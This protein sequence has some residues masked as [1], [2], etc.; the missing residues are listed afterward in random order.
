MDHVKPTFYRTI[1]F[2]FESDL[3]LQKEF[4]VVVD[5]LHCLYY[6]DVPD[7]IL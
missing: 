2:D 1:V 4:A 7:P 3:F 6:A 5:I